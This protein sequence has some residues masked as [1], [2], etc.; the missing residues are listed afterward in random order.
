MTYEQASARGLRY[1]R[2]DGATLTLSRR[3]DAPLHR[4]DHD[5]RDR[6]EEPRRAPARLLRLPP[7]RGERRRDGPGARVPAGARRRSVARRAAGAPARDAGHRGAR[8]DEPF[9]A[10]DA[11]TMP[12]GAYIVSGRAAD[13]A[14]ACATCS[15]ARSLQPEAFIKEQERRREK[16]LGDQIYDVTA[17][18]LPLAFDV[19]VVTRRSP[20]RRPRR[21]RWRSTWP[22]RDSTAQAAAA[23]RP[24]R[25]RRSATCCR[26]DRRRRAWSPRRCARASACARRTAVHARR[27]RLLR[28]ARCWCAPPRTPRPCRR[29][30]PRW[31]A[32][33]ASRWCRSTAPSSRAACRSAAHRWSALKA[34]RV[35]HGVGHRRRSRCRPAGRA[36]RS[37]AASASR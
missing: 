13:R 3:R 34:P 11:R 8:A 27:P 26:G 6:G 19:E 14:P 1:R 36:T 4:R 25:R 20:D 30:S 10:R 16:R 33:T 24:A 12:A 35:V 18:S 31:R 28:S 37:S 29:R 9:Q 32:S 21:R 7:Q 17:W 23:R 2:D 15:I 5:R 22:R